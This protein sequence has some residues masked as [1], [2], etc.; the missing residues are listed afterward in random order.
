MIRECPA[1]KG[2]ADIVF[3]P[4]KDKPA[5]IVELKWDQNT[6]TAIDQ[7]RDNEYPEVLK[8]YRDNLL[9]VAVNY[10]KH[11]KEHTCTIELF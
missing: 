10:D 2:F 3:I 6:K 8:Q 11:T 5:M 1:G 7:I 9:I 4:I